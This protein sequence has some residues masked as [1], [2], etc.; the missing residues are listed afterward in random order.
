M[1]KIWSRKDKDKRRSWTGASMVSNHDRTGSV[2]SLKEE[3]NEEIVHADGGRGAAYGGT[4]P[5]SPVGSAH[6]A[7][8]ASSGANTATTTTTMKTTR[9]GST[10]S[11]SGS[12]GSSAATSL[13]QLIK[14]EYDHRLVKN[15]WINVIINSHNTEVC[16][17]S[18]RLFRAEI[19]GSHLYLYK[20]LSPLSN[21]RSFRLDD[22]SDSVNGTVA[23]AGT[24]STDG[25]SSNGAGA[26]IHDLNPSPVGNAPSIYSSHIA[27]TTS[28]EAPSL[29]KQSTN[30][31]H[32]TLMDNQSILEDGEAT[33]SST[34]PVDGAPSVEAENSS[35]TTNLNSNSARSAAPVSTT[36]SSTLTITHFSASPHPDLHYNQETR[37]FLPSSSIEALIHFILFTPNSNAY[38]VQ[39]LIQ[40]L[41][42]FPNISQ[43]LKLVNA[44]VEAIAAKK[45]DST[46]D[47]DASTG[48]GSGTGTVSS[49][50]FSNINERLLLLLKN[51][52]DN[53]NGF[54]L[55]QDIGPIIL[56]IL[57]SLLILNRSGTPNSIEE[58]TGFLTKFESLKK[59][60]L[61]KQQVL[62]NLISP[63][64]DCQDL[65]SLTQ[66]SSYNLLSNV[67]LVE[68]AN[69]ICSIDLHYF[70]GWNSNLDKSLLL[71]SSTIEMD[72]HV[73]KNPL[74][75]NNDTHMHYLARLLVH[76]LFLESTVGLSSS[77][78]L[79]R[80]A[81]IL[82]KWIDLG[83]LL[84]KLGNMS[85]WLGIAS[86][87]LSQPILRLTRVWSLI[88]S[89]YIKLLKNDWSPVL[90]ELDRRY[91]TNGIR[92][93]SDNNDHN[94][95]NESNENSNNGGDDLKDSFHIMAPRGLGKIYPKENVVPYFG[96]LSIGNS[97]GPLNVQELEN[98]WK[99]INYSFNRWNE[100]LSNLKNHQEIIQY[101]KD[102]LRRY[103]SMGFILSNE[104]LN[105]VLYLGV[106]DDSA[107]TVSGKM[108]PHFD[109]VDTTPPQEISINDELRENLFKLIEINCKSIDLKK[110]MELSLASEPHLPENYMILDRYAMKQHRN[111]ESMSINSQES[112]PMT[113]TEYAPRVTVFNPLARIPLFNNTYFKINLNKYDELTG[114]MNGNVLEVNPIALDGKRNIVIDDELVFRIDDFIND[115]E[116]SI[117]DF[118]EIDNVDIDDDVP[119]LGID[120]DD[121]LNSDKFNNLTIESPK[122]GSRG[123][124]RPVSNGESLPMT[125]DTAS[126]SGMGGGVGGLN[127]KYLPKYASI[128]R[129]IDLLLIDA[130]FYNDNIKMDLNE[131]RFVFLLNYESF[132][133]TK[134]FLDK[135][136]HR[137]INSGNAVISIMKKNFFSKTDKP[138]DVSQFVNWDID[139]TVDLTELGEV[140][141][142]LLIKIQINILKVLIVMLNNF[143]SNFATD[144]NNRTV[145]VKLLK[146]YSN[147]I[148]QWY[149]SNKIN[150]QLEGSFEGLVNYYKRLKKLFIKKSYRP[151]EI[152][153]FDEY[154]INDFK[155]NNSLHEVPINRNLPGHKNVGKI[156]KFLH[157]FNKLLTI[158]YKGIRVEDWMKVFK[159]LEYSF[160]T[161]NMLEFNLQKNSMN[162][163]N[164]MISN[165]FTFLESL[166]D[167]KEKMLILK[168]F[169]LIFRK[170]FK[171]YYK[172]KVYLLIQL[173]DLN[174]TVDERLDRMKTLLIMVQTSK[175]KMKDH[176]FIFEGT[177]GTGIPSCIE[178]AITNV[179]Y[180]PESRTFT[181]LWVKAANSLTDQNVS[182]SSFDDLTSLLPTTI[183]EH[184]LAINHEPLLP[185]FG[186]IIENFIEV[187]KIPNYYRAETGVINFNKKYLVY[188][189]IKELGIED[190]D[191][192]T[193]DPQEINHH[194]TREF[195][196]LLKLDETLVRKQ[197]IKDFNMLEKDK[198]KLFRSV[199]KEQH[200]I[201][202]LDNKKKI[203]RD[204]L[205]SQ[206]LTL[207][208]TG[209]TLQSTLV[210]SSTGG[211][212]GVSNSANG[213]GNGNVPTTVLPG[214]LNKKN[215]SSSLRRQSLSYKSN[216]SSRFKISGLFNK[217]RPF[218]LNVSGLGGSSTPEK[219][220]SLKELPT[221]ESQIDPK[222]K[223][224]LIIPMKNKKIFPV[225]LLPL[226]FKI[227]SENSNEDY[228][229]QSC[230]E[231]DLNDWLMKLG[232]ANRHWFYSKN[233]NLKVNNPNITFGVP[234]S[235]I[236]NRE[237]SFSPSVLSVLFH[238]IETE[239]LKDV[240]IYRISSSVSDLN[241]V[242][243]IIDKTGTINFHDRSWDVHTLTS[244][245]KTYLRELPDALLTDKVIEKF[246]ETKQ[247][248]EEALEVPVGSS[249]ALDVGHSHE[250]TPFISE[251]E[252]Y[253][254]ILQ[255]LPTVNYYTLKLLLRHLQKISHFSDSNRMTPSNLAT[256]IGPALTEASSLEQLV[257]NFGFMNSILE[258][259]IVHFNYVFDED[260]EE[261]EEE[262]EEEDVVIGDGFGGVSYEKHEGGVTPSTNLEHEIEGKNSIEELKEKILLGDN[263]ESVSI[264]PIES[265]EDNGILLQETPLA[266]D[267]NDMIKDVLLEERSS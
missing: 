67:S 178:S 186:W 104:S 6:E 88:S 153:K 138:F 222:Q 17:Q 58:R 119:G 217:A 133:T 22:D 233:L 137:F 9:G 152:T 19:K 264:G 24:S 66:L 150:D 189:V 129:L 159:I 163:D 109:D 181:N 105:Q 98:V 93:N 13:S 114:V 39:Q 173:T 7:G 38:S 194:D 89:D 139:D 79:E 142:E 5:L 136:A 69:T 244:V 111:Q 123:G 203:A 135:L 202:I 266:T 108:P 149:N 122:I 182:A 72:F 157:K 81:K 236:C 103:D 53:F 165:V 50:S 80:K 25:N 63:E 65:T 118:D 140:D 146:L 237:K 47:G 62:V 261:D 250:T 84:D 110:L 96:D 260:A 95:S 185:C 143:Y 56:Q 64:V 235:L 121:I 120:V 90:F 83:C 172:F 128:D 191:P 166:N 10:S 214:S 145:L 218:S 160:E 102:V 30:A 55:N 20:L 232:F 11:S 134:D 112:L 91:L 4:A 52:Q 215:S 238:E 177:V 113:L 206:S 3:D 130:R 68:L 127:L 59:S 220:L 213:N 42:I 45:F 219:T 15:A 28:L 201:L 100:Y 221:P 12:N 192:I 32:S 200:R 164:L 101:N 183:S 141:Y 132:I 40:I 151:V 71:T 41:P 124:R 54:L 107:A 57:Q 267:N 1:R 162:D 195:E 35:S 75:F 184:D 77:A 82:E 34:A 168:K 60:M 207:T 240:G 27:S 175:L 97:L 167:S 14:P 245:V 228:F 180:S 208:S 196:F 92:V 78:I 115:M 23:P 169:P 26:H 210:G 2:S 144:L 94:E 211:G 155:F 193:G 188:K 170:L 225:Y 43:I 265:T 126:S 229:F 125:D 176:Q 131:Y 253:K 179:I 161:N 204:N 16:E 33:G 154:L 74:I 36:N 117:H 256:V 197:N 187:N 198:H 257:N 224:Y 70:Q 216:S 85:S 21:V 106:N 263:K 254:D 148:L 76:H 241:Q 8:A 51:I 242:K 87:V 231:Y 199:L 44:F 252:S 158:F 258:K 73:K 227:D 48:S 18:L 31:S 116:N 234:I 209:S 46:D 156:E 205:I 251:I 226:C 239:G 29:Y 86:I 259:L 171:L 246:F 243:S 223:P 248:I 147:E 247:A 255:S 249:S 190:L 61:A 212:N 174:I 99:K 262:E 37:T 230:N 49:G